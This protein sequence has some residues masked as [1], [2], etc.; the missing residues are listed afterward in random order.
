MSGRDSEV[1]EKWIKYNP[2]VCNRFHFR[3]KGWG[4]LSSALSGTDSGLFLVYES[5][6]CHLQYPE[7]L[8]IWE[9]EEEFV[10]SSC[11]EQNSENSSSF[12]LT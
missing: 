7:V 1:I 2:H 4:I 11:L 8:A 9:N 3:D 6:F 10:K 12:L 5:D